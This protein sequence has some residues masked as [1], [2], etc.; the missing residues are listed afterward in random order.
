MGTGSPENYSKEYSVFDIYASV[1]AKTALKEWIEKLN[2]NP[3]DEA[4][5]QNRTANV[6]LWGQY[7]L[8][9]NEEY[10]VVAMGVKY[11]EDVTDQQKDISQRY[12]FKGEELK[13]GLEGPPV[14]GVDCG[15]L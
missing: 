14:H 2:T 7:K 12:S 6:V 13:L 1:A 10:Y 3:V 8:Y 9:H 4:D 5:K 11:P 15:P